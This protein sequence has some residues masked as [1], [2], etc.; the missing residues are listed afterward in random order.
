VTLDEGYQMVTNIVGARVADLHIDMS[1]QVDF[2]FVGTELR[3]PYVRPSD[4]ALAK[5]AKIALPQPR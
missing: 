5:L 2:H 1:V 3:L 4:T